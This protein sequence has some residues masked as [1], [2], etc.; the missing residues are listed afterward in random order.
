M[1]KLIYIYIFSFSFLLALMLTPLMKWSSHFLEIF[2]H[3]GT[4]KIHEEKMP[5]LGGVAIYLAFILTL[6]INI[7]VLLLLS[8]VPELSHLFSPLAG[9]LAVT[10][11]RLAAIAGGGTLMMLIGLIDD[12]RPISAGIKFLSQVTVALIIAVSGIRIGLF[13]HNELIS[14]AITV[15]WIVAI[16]NAFNL[17]DNMD[18]LS[19]G[20][21]LVAS[22]IF[23]F[24]T[25]QSGQV[26]ITVML[27][28]FAGSLMGFLV[29]NFYPASIFMGDS[30][31]M[32]IGYILS[33]LIIMSTYYTSGSPTFMPVF[34]PMLILSVP[35]FDT[36]SVIYI[37]IKNKKPIFC[38]D[39]NHLSHR[40][41]RLGMGQRQAVCFIYLL[42]FC[43][44][45][46]ALL[47]RNLKMT[48]A[49]FV[50]FQALG[51]IAI[52]LLL[53]QASRAREKKG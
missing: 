34:M 51:V 31:S 19:A 15:F 28:L 1:W 36:L 14:M 4:R 5:I 12:Y 8:R 39:K 23:F 43:L 44:G 18:G 47:L 41:V 22:V 21:A 2:D 25:Y 13:I 6:G 27:S 48:G 42:S 38:G 30:G 40:L 46:G 50:L 49:V 26:L 35:I 52:I 7:V 37:R 20:V 16:T 45:I 32:F 33:I 11:G 3:P 24:V 10:A 17:L 9:R 53:E 29:Y